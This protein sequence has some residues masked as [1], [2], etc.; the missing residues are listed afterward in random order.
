MKYVYENCRI[1]TNDA[2]PIGCQVYFCK[3]CH[4]YYDQHYS[5]AAITK[6]K[7]Y[8]KLLFSTSAL[9]TFLMGAIFLL[10]LSA[11]ERKIVLAFSLLFCLGFFVYKIK[12][13]NMNDPN[14][15][16]LPKI[17]SLEI[18][19]NTLRE[20]IKSDTFLLIFYLVAAILGSAAALYLKWGVVL[21]PVLPLTL[22]L[23]YW[24]WKRIKDAKILLS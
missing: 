10:P 21:Y 19:K 5:E 13:F 23:A 18:F 22:L 3:S 9:L 15:R 6:Q 4:Q 16:L 12:S 17:I 14:D 2:E 24:P 7:R 8:D 20:Y 11:G 1:C